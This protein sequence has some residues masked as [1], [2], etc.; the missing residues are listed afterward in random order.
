MRRRVER[1]KF[2]WS[3]LLYGSVVAALMTKAASP[4]PSTAAPRSPAAGAEADLRAVLEATPDLQQGMKLFHIC[5]ECHGPHGAGEASGWPPEI[6]GQ[7][8]RV[9][10][11][12]LTD[13]RSGLRWYDPMERIAGR[14]VLHTTQDIADVAAYVGSLPPSAE[15]AAGAGKYL[16]RGGR[17]YASRCQ[18]CHGEK[19]QGSDQSFVPR[20]AGQQYEYL[21]RQLQDTVGGRR[22]NMRAQHIRLLESAHMEELVGLA[23]YMSRLGSFTGEPLRT[24]RPKSPGR[25]SPLT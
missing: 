18:W 11:K 17:I 6:A 19:G 25:P 10:A 1:W 3:S 20:V 15:T 21:L 14:H 5:A 24:A 7:H 13:F 8:P 22:P 16:E 12:E 9:I 23:G 4:Q 2:A